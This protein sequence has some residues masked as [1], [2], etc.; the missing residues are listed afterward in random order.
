MVGAYWV[1]ALLVMAAVELNALRAAPNT[2]TTKPLAT[3]SGT[4]HAGLGLWL[5]LFVV[6][7]ILL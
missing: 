6:A 4:V 7:S 5:V 2:A 1:V 3:V